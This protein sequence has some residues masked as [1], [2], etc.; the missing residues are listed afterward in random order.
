MWRASWANVWA[1]KLRLAMSALAVMLGVAFVAGSLIFTDTLGATF[2]GISKNTVGDVVV[3]KVGATEGQRPSAGASQE[4]TV[5]A[6]VVATLATV[7]GAAR[8]DG[9]ITV[10]GVFVVGKDGKVVGGN[11]PPAIGVNATSAPAAGGVKAFVITSGR[12]PQTEDEVVFDAFTAKRAGYLIGEQV[13]L[14]TLDQTQ[15]STARLVGI[16]DSPGLMG[17]TVSVLTTKRAQQ[18]A[19]EG[20]D[21]FTAAWVTAKPG[22]SQEDLKAAVEAA[23][24]SG[25][26][27]VTGDKQAAETASLFQEAV[28]FITNFLLVFAA[29]ALIVGTYLIVN[30]FAILV[31]Q[32]SRELALFRAIGAS[33]GQVS[34]TVLVEAFAIGVV[35]ATAGLGLGVALAMGIAR[36]FQSLGL[37]LGTQSLVFAPRTIIAAYAVG[38]VVTMLAAW[39]PARRAGRV[40]PVAA[41]RDDVA[42]QEGG[43]GRRVI[44]GT[45]LAAVGAALMYY[46]LFMDTDHSLKLLGGGILAVLLGVT[47]I[48]PVAGRPLIV[49]LGALYRATFGVVGRM[50]TQNALRTPRRTAATASALM[51][52]VTL[53]TMMSIFG[54]SAKASVDKVIAE[55]FVADYIVTSPLRQPFSPLFADKIAEVPGV[56][57]VVP[58]RNAML[59]LLGDGTWTM[60][61]DTAALARITT[62]TASEGSLAEVG[63]DRIAM[64]VGA[65][66]MFS[67]KVGDTIGLGYQGVTKSFTIVALYEAGPVLSASILL[68]PRGYDALGVPPTDSALYVTRDPGASADQV[69]GDL[70]E[71]LADQPLLSVQNQAEYAQAQ[72][73][74]IDQLLAIIYALLGL[75]VVIAILGIVNTLGLSVIERTREIGLLRAVGLSRRQLRSM[76][77][78]EAVVIAV[79]GAALGIGL[80][81]LFGVAVQRASAEDGI[82]VLVI[83]WTQL[84]AF[85]L[86]AAVVGVLAAVWPGRRA[87]KTDILRAI[88]TE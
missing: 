3:R 77:R 23:L 71:A 2:D 72:R 56:D 27:A 45:A 5:P 15:P 11:G 44:V 7:P 42:A 87:A 63:P 79:L 19:Y 53:V 59:S 82:D 16:M 52:G 81:T 61:A 10:P 39:V 25:Y 18:L 6:S 62:L 32:R 1:R 36:A 35:G 74:P 47:L 12:S 86:V 76:L 13:T 43:M 9:K 78:L 67:K 85:L 17:T 28:G 20:R 84:G 83:P 22:V 34:R 73:G 48:S 50:A 49:L 58:T 26:E 33:R 57:Q 75:A 37:D 41:M 68:D 38:I 8:A 64:D 29:I 69:A 54:S 88:T 30:T 80:G 60:A 14:L 65:A 55:Q 70:K 51:I 21:E 46:A 31:V 24:P 40:P 66:E 4:A